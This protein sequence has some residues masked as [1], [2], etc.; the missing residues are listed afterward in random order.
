[1]QIRVANRQDEPLIRTIVFQALAENGIQPDLDGI[2]KDLRNTEHS[3]YWYDGLCIVA[4]LDGQIIGV[5]AARRSFEDERL[6]VL[7]RLA[8]TPG[9]RKRG[10]ARALLKTMQFFARNMEYTTVLLDPPGNAER[11]SNPASAA[12]KAL[13]FSSDKSGQW[14]ILLN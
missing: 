5:L 2:D 13:G 9:A 4:E 12:L 11:S 3:Y 8:V 1:M 14:K 6:L 10:T 7:R